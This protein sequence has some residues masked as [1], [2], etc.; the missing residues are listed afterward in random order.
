MK[1]KKQKI[2]H[3][4]TLD[5]SKL[6]SIKLSDV[7]TEVLKEQIIKNNNKIQNIEFVLGINITSI[8]LTLKE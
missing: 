7:T 4:E 6:E 2:M 8:K 5:F 3:I 1:E